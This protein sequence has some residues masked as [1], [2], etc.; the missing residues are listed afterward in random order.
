MRT[1]VL[2]FTNMVYQNYKN[3]QSEYSVLVPNCN[4]KNHNPVSSGSSY[5]VHYMA[6]ESPKVIFIKCITSCT[7][8]LCE[9][10]MVSQAN[11]FTVST[12]TPLGTLLHVH[13]WT[14]NCRKKLMVVSL[15]F[16]IISNVDLSPP[17]QQ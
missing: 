4:C 11:F 8:C 14:I 1:S 16:G 10:N 7:T 17:V 3:V 15:L 6:A 9:T 12:C 5:T 13:E 2:S